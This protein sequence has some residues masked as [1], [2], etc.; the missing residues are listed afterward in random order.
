MNTL[1]FSAAFDLS[2]KRVILTGAAGG[3]GR[4]IAKVFAERGTHLALVDRDLAVKDLARTIGGRCIGVVADLQDEQDIVRAVDTAA[5]EF[6]GIDILVNNAG[7][8]IVGKAMGFPTEDWDRTMAIN[9]RAQFI[10]AREAA[11]HMRA[12]GWGR[13]VV[14]ASQAAVIGIDEHVA[15]SASKTGLLGM[16]RCMAIEW[17]QYGI[18]VNAISPTVVET[19]MALVGWSGEK[20]E[21]AKADIPTGRFAKPAEIALAALFLSSHAAAMITG[22]NLVVDGGRTIK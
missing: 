10:F 2:G 7:L 8:G 4:E 17:G 13:I 15:Y 22:T 5:Q 16:V 6:G 20:G 9:L 18:T 1:D 11:P 21:R 12:G 19:P 14:I 3:I